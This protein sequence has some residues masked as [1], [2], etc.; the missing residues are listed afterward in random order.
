MATEIS[1]ALERPGPTP[2]AT[3]QPQLAHSGPT[4][5]AGVTGIVFVA[6]QVPIPFLLGGA[7]GIDDPPAAIREYLVADGHRILVAT[8]L[9]TMAA[10]FF[11]WFLGGLRSYLQ[12][13]E[14]RSGHLSAIA[15]G[16]G[17]ATITLNVA[18]ST[19]V[20]ALAWNDTAASADPGLLQTVWNLNTLA[21]VPIGSTFGVLSLAV[22]AVILRT[23]ILPAW[24]GWLGVLAM[25]LG[26]ASVLLVVADGTNAVL[27]A[28][29]VAGFLVAMVF[30]LLVSIGL[31]RERHPAADDASMP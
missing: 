29:N 10:F 2:S 3:G 20:A 14:G 30:I 26:V 25:V 15:L 28:I 12:D 11:L 23:R 22:A 19:P 18:A 1:A 16:A 24:L 21:L 17:V 13:A 4:R 27:E 7:P 9:V 31:V 6:L 5:L 8:T